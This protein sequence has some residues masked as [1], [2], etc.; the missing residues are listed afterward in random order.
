MS[1]SEL[2]EQLMEKIKADLFE[3]LVEKMRTEM[4]AVFRETQVMDDMGSS[5]L[6]MCHGKMQVMIQDEVKKQL[7]A[8]DAVDTLLTD[9]K[10]DLSASLQTQVRVEVGHQIQRE[11]A[12]E[13]SKQ[14]QTKM[15][16]EVEGEQTQAPMWWGV[17]EKE[18]EEKGGKGEE[19]EEE[20][21][22]DSVSLLENSD[23]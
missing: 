3:K 2:L 6:Q 19:E 22:M 12:K 4:T 18:E 13:V 23:K 5:L 21:E 8:S 16:R 10:Y 1:A 7:N 11:V 14:M 9:L 20:E 17:I 15:A